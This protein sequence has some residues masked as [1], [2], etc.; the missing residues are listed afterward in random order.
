MITGKGTFSDILINFSSSSGN[1]RRISISSLFF[2]F[3]YMEKV[4]FKKITCFLENQRFQR[5]QWST[6]RHGFDLLMC[7][8]IQLMNDSDSSLPVFKSY[9]EKRGIIYPQFIDRSILGTEPVY[10]HLQSVWLS[11]NALHCPLCSGCQQVLSPHF[12]CFRACSDDQHIPIIVLFFPYR[13]PNERTKKN[14]T[15]T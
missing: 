10:V 6:Q 8:L 11:F 14:L 7:I 4:L 2:F 15:C 13:G 1:N 12:R 5:Q 3:L 9:Y